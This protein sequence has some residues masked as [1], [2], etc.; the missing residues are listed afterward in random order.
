MLTEYSFDLQITIPILG[1]GNLQFGD[2]NAGLLIGYTVDAGH[3]DWFVE[4]VS[5]EA[6]DASQK[7]F[8]GYYRP[9][10]D[11]KAS[12]QSFWD[13]VHIIDRTIGEH[14]DTRDLISDAAWNHYRSR[15]DSDAETRAALK[16]EM[17]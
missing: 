16:H 1:P 10:K 14:N 17:A 15:G 2:I 11:D 3:M 4:A 9:R 7:R 5:V 8:V 6:Y 12:V 13:V